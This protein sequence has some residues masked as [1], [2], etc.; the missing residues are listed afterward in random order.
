[1]AISAQ[2]ALQQLNA[3]PLVRSVQ[4]IL[5]AH[6]GEARLVGGVIR[7]ALRTGKCPDSPDLDMAMTLPPDQAMTI[8]QDHGLRVVPTGL[9]HGTIT[10]IDHRHKGVKIELT[11]LRYDRA[12]DG[13]HADVDFTA[14]WD[15]DA[16]RRDF[17]INAIYL[18]QDGTV[19]DPF[20]GIDD[21][22]KGLVRFIGDA[23]TRI[24]EDYLRMLR[25]VRFYARFGH[26]HPDETALDA[27]SRH[28]AKITTLSGERIAMELDKILTLDD[29]AQLATGRG[30]DLGQT[31]S[32]SAHAETG[33]TLSSSVHAERGETPSSSVRAETGETPSSSIEGLTLLVN[34]KISHF[35]TENGFDLEIYDKYLSYFGNNITSSL[36]GKYAALIPH[37]QA[38]DIASRLKMAN[39]RRDALEYIASSMD[40]VSDWHKCV[41]N[42]EHIGPLAW[43]EWPD[44]RKPWAAG[45]LYERFILSSLR[46]G[47]APD[48]DI[49]TMIRDWQPPQFPLQGR[50]LLKQ[51][52]DAGEDLGVILKALENYWVQHHFDP[53]ASDLVSVARKLDLKAIKG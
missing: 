9:D 1:M 15:A 38:M 52:F 35:L 2:K 33:E 3:I 14:D 12:T 40:N 20:H 7:D 53:T 48:P 47:H 11:T 51:G 42:G 36:A 44:R 45:A 32:S 41:E 37:G 23:D 46:S 31:P 50:D 22:N 28:A 24:Q 49:L 13:R 8:L 39:A 26:G 6:G 27:I 4:D 5:A 30:G 17:T 10:V 29:D 19:H 43:A 16:A 21:V 34:L 25:F 18:A